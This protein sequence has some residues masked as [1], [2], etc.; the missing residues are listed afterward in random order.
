MSAATCYET[1]KK[2]KEYVDKYCAKC[3]ISKEV[4]FTHLIVL[5]YMEYV[6]EKQ[7]NTI[8]V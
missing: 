8:I 1:N 6:M 5:N 7:S 4:A 3:G 2:F